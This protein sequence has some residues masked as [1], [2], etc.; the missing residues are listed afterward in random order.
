MLISL[1]GSIESDSESEYESDW[2]IDVSMDDVL[3]SDGIGVAEVE[4]SGSEGILNGCE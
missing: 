2:F 4:A 1:D 3:A